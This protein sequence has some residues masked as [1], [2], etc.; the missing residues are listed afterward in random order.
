M[1][2]TVPG[3]DRPGDAVM[4]AY[5]RLGHPIPR[6][7]AGP[8]RAVCKLDRMA[9]GPPTHQVDAMR[10]LTSRPETHRAAD[11]EL[12]DRGCDLVE[13]AAAIRTAADASEAV[14]ATPALLG[15]LEA[16]LHELATAVAAL[17]ATTER[18]VAQPT[19]G[20]VVPMRE[21]MHRGYANLGQALTD[22]ERAAVAARALAGRLLT[23]TGTGGP[24]RARR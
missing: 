7:G 12:Y 11:N 21:R 13:A 17:E 10:A 5:R 9:S 18:A 14:R 22:A 23:A 16:A 2:N 15:C 24:D 3:A 8:I 19:R 4:T 6:S 1:M 20:D